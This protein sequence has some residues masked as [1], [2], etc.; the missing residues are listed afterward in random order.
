M[1]DLRSLDNIDIGKTATVTA[2]ELDGGIKQ[3]LRD[4]G[5]TE[6]ASVEC[7]GISPLGDPIALLVGGTVVA[8]RK[9][10]CKRII[11]QYGCGS[12]V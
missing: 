7:V 10:D 2:I 8:V 9:Q 5:I 3:R 6:G 4:I 1:A 12:D 11:A